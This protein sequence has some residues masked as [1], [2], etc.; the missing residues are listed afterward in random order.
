MSS[1][2]Q[3]VTIRGNNYFVCEYTGAPITARYFLPTGKKFTGKAHCCATLPILARVLLDDAKGDLQNPK[4]QEQLGVLRTFYKQDAIPVAP[5]VPAEQAGIGFDLTAYLNKPSGVDLGASW[6]FV[7][8][9][10][11]IEDYLG[12]QRPKKKGSNG[13]IVPK[14]IGK[15][16]AK[17]R[18]Y[19]FPRGLYMVNARGTVRAIGENQFVSQVAN[20]HGI[21]TSQHSTGAAFFASAQPVTQA[22]ANPLLRA[23]EIDEDGDVIMSV[24]KKTE[25][26]APADE[27][28]GDEESPEADDE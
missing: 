1:T 13:K 26:P 4:F 22:G 28:D 6:L 11:T 17:R 12:K 23:W 16:D 20:F 10:Q 3:T 24:S 27:S 15:K 21:S 5:A 19:V 18:V 2:P 7:A 9:A 25:L 14:T 8:G